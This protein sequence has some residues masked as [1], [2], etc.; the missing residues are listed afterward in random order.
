VALARNGPEG[1]LGSEVDELSTEVALVLGHVLVERGGQTG[2][3]PG[4]GLWSRWRR[5]RDGR[6]EGKGKKGSCD[7]KEE[8]DRGTGSVSKEWERARGVQ[9]EDRTLVLWSTK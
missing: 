3:V 2:V 7:W 6:G 9:E 1:G 8:G 5:W 4:G